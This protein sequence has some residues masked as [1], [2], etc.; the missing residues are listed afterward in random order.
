MTSPASIPGSSSAIPLNG[1][2]WP[3]CIPL[4]IWTSKISFSKIFDWIRLFC[5][6]DILT[7]SDFLSFTILT[8]ILCRPCFSLT[9]AFSTLRLNLLNHWTHSL[10]SNYDSIIF[11]RNSFKRLTLNAR[12]TAGRT[13]YW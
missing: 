11:P 12:S 5:D 3:F 13:F 6:I 9:T 4:S 2:F 7:S 1:I 8:F 10:N